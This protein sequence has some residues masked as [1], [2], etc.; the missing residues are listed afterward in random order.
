MSCVYDSLIKKLKLKK[1]NPTSLVEYLKENNT[2]TIDTTWN[3]NFL[4]EQE[5]KDNKER[6][7]NIKGTNKG[8]DC[9]TCDPLL[10]LVCQIYD[11]SIYHNFNGTEISYENSKISEK[12]LETKQKGR[13]RKKANYDAKNVKAIKIYMRSDEGHMF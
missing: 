10:L 11:V 3:G 7:S 6:I 9:S 2:E 13:S 5:M 4:T 12:T 1:T 8:Y